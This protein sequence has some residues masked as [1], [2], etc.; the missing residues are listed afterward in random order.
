MG[1]ARRGTRGSGKS[2]SKEWV[3]NPLQTSRGPGSSSEG[4]AKDGF[5]LNDPT[6]GSLAPGLA[7][8]PEV[9]GD[10]DGRGPQGPREATSRPG[11]EAVLFLSPGPHS[12]MSTVWVPGP[13]GVVTTAGNSPAAGR[14]VADHRDSATPM[15][16]MPPPPPPPPPQSSPRPQLRG[17][18]EDKGCV[19]GVGVGGPPSLP[20]ARG[21]RVSKA[22]LPAGTAA[23]GPPQS[24]HPASLALAAITPTVHPAVGEASVPL[25]GDATHATGSVVEGGQEPP[26]V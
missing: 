15:R 24:P 7:H 20:R 3:D 1:G 12:S 6:R 21:A 22:L 10:G 5:P 2:T 26:S 18:V 11:S 16:R 8:G 19:P 9:Q 17:P 4:A 13:A 25:A 23:G 14:H